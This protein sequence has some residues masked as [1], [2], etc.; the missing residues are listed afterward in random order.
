MSKPTEKNGIPEGSELVYFTLQNKKNRPE[1]CMQNKFEKTKN[2]Q[3][4]LVKN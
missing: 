4:G 2:K 1:T 3:Y